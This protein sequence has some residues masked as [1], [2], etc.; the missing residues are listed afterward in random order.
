MAQEGDWEHES[1]KQVQAILEGEKIDR[2]GSPYFAL[3]FP[4]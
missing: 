1:G 4:F 2:R 3:S